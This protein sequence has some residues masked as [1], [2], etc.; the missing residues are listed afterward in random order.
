MQVSVEKTSELSRIMTVI[1]PEEVV[2]EKM[3]TRFKTLAKDVKLDGFRPGKVPAK[4]VKKMFGGRVRGEVTGDIIQTTY[5]E[6]LQQQDLTPAGHPKIQPSDAQEGLEYTAEFEVYPKVS[7]AGIEKIEVMRPVSEVTDDDLDKM[8]EK[9]REQKKEWHTVER[10]AQEKD[11]ITLHFSGT[12]EGEN[13]TD[14]KVED[15]QVEIGEKQMIPGFENN[16]LGVKAGE[17][18]TFTVTFPEQYGNEK[19]AGKVAEFEIEVL[20]VE[21]SRLPEVDAEFIKAHGV[22]NGDLNVLRSD[23][24]ANMENE[25][26]QAVKNKIKNEVMDGLYAQLELP[27]PNAM[28]DQEIETLM[29]PYKEQA[30]REKIDFEALKL[31]RDSFADQA[32]KRVALG[33]IFAEVIKQNDIKVDEAKV[34]AVIEKMAQSYDH[35]EEV[36]S[37][38]Y[39][40]KSRLTEIEQMVLED[41]SVD[42]LLSQIKV[43]D[44]SANFDDL[45]N[46]EKK[47]S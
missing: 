31:S 6:A 24:R 36:I 28:V 45:I 32:K 39:A 9:L 35:P 11:Q 21:E 15:F 34:R 43:T 46:P 3:E 47:E 40:D 27:I 22:E 37:W 17:E 8:I 29:K 23:V 7:L 2:Q 19:I 16:L 38:H 5:Y 33:L 42:W 30:K 41:E 25:L 18:K 4:V 10:E 26:E 13:F 20:K 12:S 1:V 14:G 44:E